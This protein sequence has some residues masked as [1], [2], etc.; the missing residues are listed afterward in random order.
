MLHSFEIRECPLCNKMLQLKVANKVHIYKC[1]TT[2]ELS[3]EDKPEIRSH[4]EVEV[5]GKMDVQHMYV[6]VYSIDNFTNGSRSRIYHW[7]AN[8]KGIFRW[9]FVTEVPRIRPAAQ[10]KLEE[11]IKALLVFL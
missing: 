8:D 4:Y 5:D 3:Q 10:N 2:I 9:K 7:S 11:K 1:P 6:G